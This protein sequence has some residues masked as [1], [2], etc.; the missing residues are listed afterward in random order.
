MSQLQIIDIDTS[1]I[2]SPL[3]VIDNDSLSCIG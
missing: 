2:F 1:I 3:Q